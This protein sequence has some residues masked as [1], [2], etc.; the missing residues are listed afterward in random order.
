V[1]GKALGWSLL[2]L[3]SWLFA[4][5]SWLFA[6]HT[7]PFERS[8]PTRGRSRS[9]AESE[10]SLTERLYESLCETSPLPREHRREVMKCLV[11]ERGEKRFH[12][13]VPGALGGGV[14]CGTGIKHPEYLEEQPPLRDA[15][16]RC[17]EIFKGVIQGMLESRRCPE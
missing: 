15:C 6:P 17:R 3:N 1:I 12:M 16:K 9:Q 4:L 5:S 13:I 2:R 11:R 14:F 10:R 7:S 8:V